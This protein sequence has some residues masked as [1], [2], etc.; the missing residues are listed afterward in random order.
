MTYPKDLIVHL[1]KVAEQVGRTVSSLTIP[2]GNI[3]VKLDE[4]D[5]DRNA[6]T[7]VCGGLMEATMRKAL[8]SPKCKATDGDLLVEWDSK[9]YPVEVKFCYSKHSQPKGGEQC[10]GRLHI[11]YWYREDEAT[12]FYP[13]TRNNKGEF[14]PVSKPSTLGRGRW[15]K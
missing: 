10:I 9:L 3:S 12:F 4:S 8:R 14:A 6:F 5:F 11:A 1:M 2:C 13:Q 15:Q 7:A